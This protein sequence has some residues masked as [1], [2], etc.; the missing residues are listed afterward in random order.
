MWLGGLSLDD[1]HNDTHGVDISL[2]VGLGTEG[3]LTFLRA[4]KST[5]DDVC[6]GQTCRWWVRVCAHRHLTCRP[7]SPWSKMTPFDC[8]PLLP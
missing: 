6:G 1:G 2:S 4:G 5:R 3:A 8:F 7:P